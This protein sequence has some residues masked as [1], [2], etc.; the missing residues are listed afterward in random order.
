[1]THEEACN[2]LDIP[3]DANLETA[4]AAHRRLARQY[5]PDANPLTGGD[6]HLFQLVDTHLFQLVTDAWECVQETIPERQAQEEERRRRLAEERRRRQEKEWWKQQEEIW[7]AEERQR[8]QEEEWWRQEEE[9]RRKQEEERWNAKIG[10]RLR[11]L[12]AGHMGEV[13]S[14]AYSPDGLTIASGS[15]DGTIRIWNA[16]TGALLRT[17]T[18][19][20]DRFPIAFLIKTHTSI[21]SVAYSPYGRTIARGNGDGTIRIWN[22][23]TETLLRTLTGHTDRV[24]SVAY[25]PD[26]RT[27]AS[28]SEDRTVRIWNAETGKLL[29]TL[30]GHTEWVSSVAYSPDGL[31]IA[32][33]SGGGTIRIWNAETG[34][35]LRTLRGHSG[36]IYSVAYSP[37]GQTIACS[38]AVLSDDLSI[39]VPVISACEVQIWNAETGELLRKLINYKGRVNSVAFLRTVGRLP[40]AAGQ[41]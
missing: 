14:V 13:Y 27:I 3:L 19:H 34:K 6:T 4:R 25:S 20:T 15:G 9:E 17:L 5:H 2:I 12:A 36:G 37:D 35:L 8:E 41:Y 16:Q 32:S 7:R 18:G 33:V 11:T 30:R 40:V 31:T 24:C 10:S 21:Y 29:R 26:G 28:G 1:M 38:G 22:A 23:Q 39:R